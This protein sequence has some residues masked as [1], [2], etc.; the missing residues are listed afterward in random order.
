M[1]QDTPIIRTIRSEA[2]ETGIP[3]HLIRN[4]VKQN[5]IRAIY[6]GT[7]AYVIHDSLVAYLNGEAEK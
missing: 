2:R 5:K 1:Q 7:R 3:E 6:A 4:L